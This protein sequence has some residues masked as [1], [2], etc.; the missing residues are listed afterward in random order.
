MLQYRA[1]KCL[2]L[3][4]LHMSSTAVHRQQPMHGKNWTALSTLLAIVWPSVSTGVIKAVHRKYTQCSKQCCCSRWKS[5]SSRTNLQ[6][7]VLGLKVL[8]FVLVLGPEILVLVLRPQ[9]LVLEPFWQHYTSVLSSVVLEESPCLEDLRGPI[10][11]SLSSDFKSLSLNLKFLTTW[12]VLSTL[13]VIQAVHRKYTSVHSTLVAT[14]WMTISTR[15]VQVVTCKC[16][17]WVTL[18][19]T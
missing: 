7:L 4:E 10:Y 17:Q 14:M 9:V 12:L 3:Q 15:V 16:I 8:I 19:F 2:L 18:S 11:K 6:V 5:L 1:N 13:G